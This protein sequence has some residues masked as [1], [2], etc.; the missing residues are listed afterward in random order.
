MQCFFKY[1]LYVD[2]LEDKLWNHKDLHTFFARNQP[3][4]WFRRFGGAHVILR[5]DSE[6][7]FSARHY[8]ADCESVV[9]DAICNSVPLSFTWI[10]LSHHVVQPVITFLIWR[11]GPW[12][13]HCARHV[14]IN[15]HRT[16]WLGLIWSSNRKVFC[17]FSIY[18]IWENYLNS[19]KVQYFTKT[20]LW[21]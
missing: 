14:F 19:K 13:G 2:R 5:V 9:E 10:T 8:V 15:L 7:V 3:L 17:F 12:N 16:W 1:I 11:W 20:H 21:L 4:W 18:G 6:L